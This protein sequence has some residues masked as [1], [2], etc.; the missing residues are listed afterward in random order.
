[1]LTTKHPM[2]WETLNLS[3]VIFDNVTRTKERKKY[4]WQPSASISTN[5]FVL[6]LRK[7][8]ITKYHV[9]SKSCHL[10]REIASKGNYFHT[11]EKHEP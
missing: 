1:M 11:F 2:C 6:D 4:Q 7:L 10:V 9:A 5:F 3:G 8:P